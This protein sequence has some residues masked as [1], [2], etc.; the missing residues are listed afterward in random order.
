MTQQ[1]DSEAGGGDSQPRMEIHRAMDAY[2]DQ[3]AQLAQIRAHL[4]TVRIEACSVDNHVKVA[5]D[6]TGV[7][8]EIQLE[9]PA[10]RVKPDELARKL[11]EVAREAAGYA[12]KYTAEALAP[13][14]EIV[15][16]MP[17][18]PDLVPGAPSLRG[19]DIPGDPEDIPPP[20]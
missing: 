5:V 20:Q 13:V 19:P 4:D 10:M 9:R 7:V 12:E 11:T 15:G 17:D 3:I 2:E 1:F 16:A 18:L 14:S 8:T 6:S